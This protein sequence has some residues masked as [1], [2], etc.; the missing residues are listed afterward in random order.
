MHEFVQDDSCLHNP[1]CADL[2]LPEVPEVQ[3]DFESFNKKLL[4]AAVCIVSL[5]VL[6]SH[7]ANMSLSKLMSLHVYRFIR[8]HNL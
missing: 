6:H 8:Q 7:T 4:V 5:L 3:T 2:V 1:V